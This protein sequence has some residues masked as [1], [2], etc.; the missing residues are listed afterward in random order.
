[1]WEAFDD[2]YD[3]VFKFI[4]R[5]SHNHIIWPYVRCTNIFDQVLPKKKKKSL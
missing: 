1:M 4:V 5:E 2:D 3:D